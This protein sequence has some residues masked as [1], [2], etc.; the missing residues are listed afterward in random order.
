MKRVLQVIIAA[1][2]LGSLSLQY[3][4]TGVSLRAAYAQAGG[5]L[6]IDWTP[7]TTYT[8][9]VPLLEQDMDFYTF[10]C[11]G[12]PMKTIDLVVG[13]YHDDVDISQWPSN[14]Y[15][16]H[17]TITSLLGQESDPSNTVNFT[18]GARKPGTVT[19]LTISP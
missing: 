13:T 11:N 12:V 5:I 17:L 14:D 6:G 7:P 3:D 1:V 18:I 15:T 9:G 2:L 4:T 10:F 16:C 19:G 8:D